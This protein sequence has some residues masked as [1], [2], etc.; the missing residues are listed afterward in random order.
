MIT[1]VHATLSILDT[2]VCVTSVE[3]TFCTNPSNV[4]RLAMSAYHYSVLRCA[5]D[6]VIV[7]LTDLNVFWVV[8]PRTVLLDTDGCRGPTKG[9]G[10]IIQSQTVTDGFVR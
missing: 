7:V 8:P 9:A 3:C 1:V 10:V 2:R 4:V 5:A 6:H